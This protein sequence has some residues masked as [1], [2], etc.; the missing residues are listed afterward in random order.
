MYIAHKSL[1]A[2]LLA[3]IAMSGIA[4]SSE[5]FTPPAGCEA[6]LT[7]QYETC[8]ADIYW[9]CGEDQAAN[10]WQAYYSADGLQSVVSYSSQYA[11]LSSEIHWDN[12]KEDATGTPNDPVSLAMLSLYGIDTYDFDL[13]R[14]DE[15]GARLLHVSGYDLLTDEY[16]EIDGTRMKIMSYDY[17]ITEEDGSTYFQASGAQLLLPELRLF[18]SYQDIVEEYGDRTTYDIAPVE[19]IYPGEPGFGDPR[20]QYGCEATEPD[21]TEIPA[22]SSDQIPPGP[23][24]TGT[25][26]NHDK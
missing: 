16:M 21:E 25:G 3:L 8:E 17:S 6:I 19:I 26:V 12:S 24:E 22:P 10:T 7:V 4:H 2:T 11:W 9:R 23:V 18:L 20:P 14:T 5:T 1:S 13:L 15:A